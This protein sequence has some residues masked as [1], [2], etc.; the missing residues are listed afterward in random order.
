MKPLAL[1]L[2][3]VSIF[4][5][6]ACAAPVTT[7]QNVAGTALKNIEQVASISQPPASSNAQTMN[8]PKQP[9]SSCP[10]TLPTA[11]LF[12]PPSPY[13]KVAPYGGFWYGSDKLWL[14][15]HPDGNWQQLLHGDKVFWWSDGYEGNDEPTPP[16]Q[17]TGRQLD[18]DGTFTSTG[19]TNAL[20]EDFGG[21]T[22]LTGVQV[23]GAGC[24]EIIGEYETTSLKFVVQVNP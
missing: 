17:V 16:L 5:L 11:K 3:T 2:A 18:G 24:W 1:L 22:M 8:T 4:M 14:S 21:W 6:A 19:A 7:T 15:L 13:P 20:H 12:V 10:A 23:P 9:S